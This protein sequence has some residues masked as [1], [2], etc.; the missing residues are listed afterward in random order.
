MRGQACR[1]NMGCQGGWRILWKIRCRKMAIW[2]RYSAANGLD[3]LEIYDWRAEAV[4]FELTEGFLFAGFQDQC[5]KTLAAASKTSILLRAVESTLIFPDDRKITFSD[6]PGSAMNTA[7]N[8]STVETGSKLLTFTDSAADKIKQLIDEED[9]PKLKLRVF[10]QGGGCAGFQYGF[11]FE[12][13]EDK[14]HSEQ[15]NE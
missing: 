14:A 4:R 10:V 15:E 6:S 1:G 11:T 7:L 9:N 5:L 13:E 3:G 8:S 2:D 12:D